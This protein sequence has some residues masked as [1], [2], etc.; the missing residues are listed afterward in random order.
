[1]ESYSSLR[2]ICG[3]GPVVI[4]FLLHRTPARW[5]LRTF[6][7]LNILIMDVHK[8]LADIARIEP[9]AAG[10]A[11]F[12]IVGLG[13]G[14]RRLFCSSPFPCRLQAQ[15]QTALVAPLHFPLDN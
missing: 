11:F 8:H 5:R 12:E 10:R 1:M 7:D 2:L 14:S 9:L 13:L 4:A 3:S 15:R 6:A